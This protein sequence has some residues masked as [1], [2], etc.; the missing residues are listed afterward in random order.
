MKSSTFSATLPKSNRSSNS[1]VQDDLLSRFTRVDASLTCPICGHDSW[2]LI[3]RDGSGV[4]CQRTESPK[5]YGNAGWFHK[6]NVMPVKKA[7]SKSHAKL[8][9]EE[10]AAKHAEFVNHPECVPRV[11]QLAESLSLSFYGMLAMGVGWTGYDWAFPMHNP[12]DGAV[13]G[14]R[15]RRPDGTKRSVRGG[16]E[17]L[18]LTAEWFGADDT[19]FIAEGATDTLAL[20]KLGLEAIG[21]PSCTGGAGYVR[22]VCRIGEYAKIVIVAD[23]DTPGKK[24]ALALATTLAAEYGDVFVIGP[25]H[26]KDVREYVADG[27]DSEGI[28]EVTDAK[29]NNTSWEIITP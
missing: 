1:S 8:S 20:D 29:R 18:F 6:E 11:K 19:L 27:G 12:N 22:D 24:G 9:L 14:F 5:R 10:L 23:A 17:G 2:C 25:R 16:S 15:L 28:M 13:V 26:H 21:R 3:L 7:A 4:I